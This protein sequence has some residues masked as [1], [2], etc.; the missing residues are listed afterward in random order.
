[1]VAKPA[2]GESRVDR[3]KALLVSIRFLRDQA[4]AAGFVEAARHLREAID[5]LEGKARPTTH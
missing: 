5:V 1:M 3:R 2:D 4:E